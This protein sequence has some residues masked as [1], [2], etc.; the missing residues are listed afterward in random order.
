[1]KA[2]VSSKRFKNPVVTFYVNGYPNYET[3]SKDRV[4]TGN[5]KNP[6]IPVHIKEGI[7]HPSYKHMKIKDKKMVVKTEHMKI[8]RRYCLVFSRIKP[9]IMVPKDPQLLFKMIYIM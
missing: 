8:T 2:K 1:M 5:P 6:V 3:K 9:N 7:Y 4:I